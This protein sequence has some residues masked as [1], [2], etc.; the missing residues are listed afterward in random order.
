MTVLA[1][2]KL[3][4]AEGDAAAFR[5]VSILDTANEGDRPLRVIMPARGRTL[6]E[7]S[8]DIVLGLCVDSS[9]APGL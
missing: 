9:R 4:V 8:I 2:V 6:G 1:R 7:E 5:P 3:N